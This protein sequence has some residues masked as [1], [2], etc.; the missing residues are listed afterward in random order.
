MKDGKSHG[1]NGSND[2][3]TGMTINPNSVTL[4]VSSGASPHS[5]RSLTLFPGGLTPGRK[6]AVQQ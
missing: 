5:E 4:W 3:H 6:R 1:V 2:G